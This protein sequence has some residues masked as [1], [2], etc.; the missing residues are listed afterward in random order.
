MRSLNGRDVSAKS[1]RQLLDEMAKDNEVAFA[2]LF[3][4]YWEALLDSSYRVLGDKEGAQD[5]VQEVFADL[6]NKRRSLQ[7]E[8]VSA[9]LHQSSRYAVFR[10][11][12]RSKEIALDF[13][14]SSA[15]LTSN[16]TEQQLEFQELSALLEDSVSELPEQ[17]QRVFRLSRFE[18]LT[19]KEIAARLD[20][21]V[22]TVDNH[23]AK[24]L[25]TLR[26]KMSDSL[27]FM[28]LLMW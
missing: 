4:R 1:D 3:D 18:H 5:A 14:L 19:N 13:D 11:I 9:Y 26:W 6:W 12:R 25:E 2:M 20:I 23:I 28:L 24:A 22:R 7:V 21:S 16:V 27:I 17:C 10:L 8:K 15:P